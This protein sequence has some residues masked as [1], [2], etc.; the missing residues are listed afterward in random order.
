MGDRVGAAEPAPGVVLVT[1]CSTV[2]LAVSVRRSRAR[3]LVSK[4]VT[5]QHNSGVAHWAEPNTRINHSK[6]VAGQHN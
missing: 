3:T 1:H 2:D 5:A 4:M 6:T